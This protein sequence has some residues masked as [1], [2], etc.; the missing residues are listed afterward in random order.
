[1]RD[2]FKGCYKIDDG[3]GGWERCEIPED[4]YI[5]PKLEGACSGYKETSR[6]ES[7]AV[8]GAKA[9]YKH[10]TCQTT[11]TEEEYNNIIKIEGVKKYK[12]SSF[13]R[14]IKTWTKQIEKETIKKLIFNGKHVKKLPSNCADV[15]TFFPEIKKIVYLDWYW[16][17]ARDS[18]ETIVN[19][20]KGFADKDVEVEYIENLPDSLEGF[21]ELCEG[22]IIIDFEGDL[23]DYSLYKVTENAF[24]VPHFQATQLPKY[25]SVPNGSYIANT[26]KVFK[27]DTDENKQGQE[28]NF[29]NHFT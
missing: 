25:T 2:D 10:N 20:I 27:V 29:L 13:I 21:G 5:K 9:F 28:I 24:K 18:K 17:P 14:F 16:N 19:K 15:I 1:M 11:L 8:L 7:G 23:F 4:I 6:E 3:K 26:C 12:M 22:S